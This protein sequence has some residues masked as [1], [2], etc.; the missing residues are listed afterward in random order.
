MRIKSII[1]VLLFSLSLLY[2]QEN[3]QTF[4]S[5]KQTGVED[6]LKKN[7]NCDGRG[8]I[9][10]VFD[11]GVDMGIDGLLKTSTGE[12]KV[13]DV[14]DFTNEGDINYYPA[15][16][17]EKD[18]KK[19]FE[20]EELKYSV[21]GAEKLSVAAFD[22]NYFIGAIKED[23]WKN[24]SSA[25]AD[26]NGN[27]KKDDTFYFVVF[28]TTDDAENSWVVFFDTNGNGDLSDEKPIKNYKQNKDSFSIINKDLPQLTMGL[29]IFPKEK[30][31]NFHFDDG[32][33]GTH[34]AGIATGYKIGGVDLN[35]VAPGAYVISCK[36]GNN[37]YSGGAT[38]TES[39]KKAFLYADKISKE[40]KNYCVINMS[41]GVGSEI[42]GN[43]DMEKFIDDLVA[44]N[45]YLYISLSNGNE[46]PGI[47]T[48][49]LPA[50]SSSVLSSGAVL[51]KE[52][53]SDLYGAD[54]DNDIILY[55]SSR[56]GEVSKPDI[57]SPGAC[58][59]TVPNWGDNDRFWGTSM[60]SPYTAGVLSLLLSAVKVDYPDIKVPSLL[61][62]KAV[63]E[64]ATKWNQ[65]ASI[66]QG[67]GFINVDKA[68][69]LLKKYIKD[70]EIEKFETYKITA[71]SPN[72]PGGKA[73]NL[74]L[75][76]GSYLTG[77]E[78]YT[79]LV[80]R[81]KFDKNDKFYRVYN[82][83]CDSDWLIPMQKKTY[84]RNDQAT[85][86]NVR[87]DK[88]KMKNPGMYN[89]KIK[90]FRE[91]SDKY[92]EFEMMATVIIPEEFSIENNY[93][94]SWTG[95]LEKA[96]YKRYFVNVPAGATSMKI[97]LSSTP[98]KYLSGR[99]N[100]HA[101]NGR[102]LDVTNTITSEKDYNQVERTYMNLEPGVYELVVESSYQAKNVSTY[103]FNVDFFGINLIG[104][105]Q[106]CENNKTIKV[107]NEF[108]GVNTYNLNGQILGYEKS[109]YITIK[110]KDFYTAPFELAENEA[111]RNFSIELTKED[112]NK[113]TDFTILA[114]DKTGFAV[115]KDGLSY[116]TGELTVTNNEKLGKAEYK[117]VI[118]P[119]FANADSELKVLIKEKT[120]FNDSI[121]L[122]VK[123]KNKKSV[124]LYPSIPEE[125]KVEYKLPE[126]TIPEG[127][128]LFGNIN[129]ESPATNKVEYEIP[130]NV[131]K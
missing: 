55:F 6:F 126:L 98:G 117:L 102:Q 106:L 61:L 63:R 71:S 79:F 31:V 16:I 66:D 34:V 8:T 81:N 12:I 56:G 90:A 128:K 23:F 5:L 35:G 86:I 19:Y 112:F 4:L 64:S 43:A 122:N 108:N 113:I 82:I 26:I 25:I 119:G 101:P 17:E 65:Y 111:E 60:A 58:T 80:E 21:L 99:I 40:T 87:F 115:E 77:N 46:G 30:V 54:L 18:G 42:E 68:Y 10:F 72:M 36:L 123:C 131:S 95:E 29:N 33:H 73:P 44:K 121:D 104:K 130:I 32:G 92:T 38:V 129:F 76:N 39:M 3:K 97:K 114:Y 49:G 69:D 83:E 94:K 103:N 57:V 11:T 70:G 51:T 96:M 88:S 116:S 93:R 105:N 107:V 67:S 7:P 2:A 127:T 15:T 100:L 109:Y 50:A 13:I 118:I 22:D 125:L 37:N 75:R 20:N 14:Q 45:P 124:N 84:L 9:V 48:A 91:G 28:Q 89:A 59:S 120:Y 41:F 1:Y 52:V 110:G 78:T 62:Y 27:D 85:A 74:Y 47:S 53:G 24:S